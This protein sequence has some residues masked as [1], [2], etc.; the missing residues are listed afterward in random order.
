MTSKRLAYIFM[1]LPYVA[2]PLDNLKK[3]LIIICGEKRES[4][5]HTGNLEIHKTYNAHGQLTHLGKNISS[6]S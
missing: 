5:I 1:L 2:I 4:S 6:L 3:A